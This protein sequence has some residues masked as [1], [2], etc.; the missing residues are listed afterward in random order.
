[1]IWDQIA[2][3]LCRPSHPGNIGS[4]ARAMKTMGIYKLHLVSPQHLPNE[5]SYALA[6]G[7]SD[8]LDQAHIHEELAD[9][10]REAH[11]VL[12]F[13]SRRRELS[14]TVQDVRP[15]VAECVRHLHQGHRIA[16]VFGTERFG[17]SI[18]ELAHCNRLVT[19][20]GNPSYFSLNLSQ[21]VQI[22][23]YEF[24]QQ[25]TE[26]NPLPSQ[27]SASENL[28]SRQAYDSFYRFLEDTLQTTGF[29]PQSRSP[30]RLLRRLRVLFDRAQVQEE[31]MDILH[32]I[33]KS[34]Q[35]NQ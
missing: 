25:L 4:A 10:L 21:A 8:V 32:G 11:L 5:E 24:Y 22:V 16:L 31:E 7:A 18:E 6:S 30:E 29:L 28:A 15:A 12:G 26:G 33:L 20:P 2:M 34:I 27:P 9:A 17:L 35:R 23:A 13:T 1:M 3:V 14:A 19:I